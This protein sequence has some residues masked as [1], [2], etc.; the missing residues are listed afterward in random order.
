MFVPSR[1]RKALR[2]GIL[3]DLGADSL[4]RFGGVCPVG[5][6]CGRNESTEFA[7]ISPALDGLLLYMDREEDCCT[8]VLLA[9]CRSGYLHST[10]VS[11]VL[12]GKTCEGEIFTPRC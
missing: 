10:G 1:Q 7:R 11:G 8:F 3:L 2:V 6:R 9:V 4:W 5:C 12:N